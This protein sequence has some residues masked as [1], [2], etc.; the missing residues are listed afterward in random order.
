MDRSYLP[1]R[2]VSAFR[3]ANI[4]AATDELL[5]RVT[6]AQRLL[7]RTE[8]QVYSGRSVDIHHAVTDWG[9]V[10]DNL[11]ETAALIEQVLDAYFGHEQPLP[12]PESPPVE[13]AA[14]S[15]RPADEKSESSG[16]PSV[17]G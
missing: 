17:S 4:K 12:M 6:H 7:L 3:L 14:E 10:K 9:R 1:R 2:D 15:Q 16:W 13:P 8:A 11:L 5:P